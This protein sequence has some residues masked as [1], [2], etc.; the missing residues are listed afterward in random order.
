MSLASDV[1]R[2]DGD[3]C[4]PLDFKDGLAE[5]LNHGEA[6]KVTLFLMVMQELAR[7]CHL[8][9]SEEQ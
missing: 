1:C 2:E 9:V 5:M 8:A 7:S 4:A 6:P 3:F